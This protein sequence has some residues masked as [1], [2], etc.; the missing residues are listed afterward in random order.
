MFRTVW[1][2]ISLRK[3]PTCR[4]VTTGFPTK[5]RLR[6]ERGDSILMTRHYPDLGST[7]DWLSHISHAARSIRRTTQIWVVNI[8]HVA[9][10]SYWSSVYSP[11]LAANFGFFEI[12]TF[13]RSPSKVEVGTFFFYPFTLKISSKYT[14]LI[15]V[16]E[17]LVWSQQIFPEPY[18]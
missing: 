7:S 15:H 18:L 10:I 13:P 9:S 12:R 8:V 17:A 5:W 1:A 4:D 3:Q 2:D 16:L 14:Y 6:N 11:Y